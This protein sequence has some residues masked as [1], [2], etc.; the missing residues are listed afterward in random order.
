M[1]METCQKPNGTLLPMATPR[2]EVHSNG[3]IDTSGK[4]IFAKYIN[5]SKYQGMTDTYF[6][7]T[8][9]LLVMN[10]QQSGPKLMD[11]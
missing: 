7:I 6:I 11:G 4:Y 1:L 5:T 10:V 8:D 2:V 9:V 3:F